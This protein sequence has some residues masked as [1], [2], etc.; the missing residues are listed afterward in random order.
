MS[1]RISTKTRLT[2]G[3]A[4]ALAFLSAILEGVIGILIVLLFTLVANIKFLQPDAWSIL[5]E[6]LIIAMAINY[7]TLG[8]IIYTPLQELVHYSIKLMLS[9]FLAF[10]TII[11][12][13]IITLHEPY[14]S[15]QIYGILTTVIFIVEAIILYSVSAIRSKKLA[16]IIKHK[17]A[18][19]Q[20]LNLTNALAEKVHEKDMYR[21]LVRTSSQALT[22]WGLILHGEMLE[23]WDLAKV[24]NKS[25]ILSLFFFGISYIFQAF[26]QESIGLIALIGSIATFMLLIG[27]ITFDLIKSQKIRKVL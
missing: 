23:K 6:V 13:L 21:Q 25:I 26:Y 14:S 10:L 12:I 16:I 7:F 27:L 15:Y 5:I 9:G 4:N 3:F 17:Q 8:L 22:T 20:L 2:S 18:L 11:S 1:G 24:F 19:D